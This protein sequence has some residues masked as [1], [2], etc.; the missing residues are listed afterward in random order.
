[1]CCELVALSHLTK[2]AHWAAQCRIY[3]VY[4][5]LA[6]TLRMSVLFRIN[7]LARWSEMVLKETLNVVQ[8]S[9]RK[10]GLSRFQAVLCLSGRPCVSLNFYILACGVLTF[11]LVFFLFETDYQFK[12]LTRTGKQ[13]TAWQMVAKACLIGSVE[14]A[15]VCW[16]VLHIL[17][18]PFK[19]RPKRLVTT[20]NLLA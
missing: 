12:P 5:E 10:S 8:M 15:G 16:S 4:P 13:K 11:V 7:V 17:C 18:G 20:S 1:M 14:W 19:M 6:S 2:R 9:K 3:T